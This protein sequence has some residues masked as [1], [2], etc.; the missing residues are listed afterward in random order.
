LPSGDFGPVDFCELRWFAWI[1]A[2]DAMR[3]ACFPI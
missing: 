3:E 2:D 1:C